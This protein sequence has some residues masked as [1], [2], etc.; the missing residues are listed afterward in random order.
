MRIF[1][2]NA[3]DYARDYE[4]NGYAHVKGGVEPE[5]LKFALQQYQRLASS[6]ADM[7]EWEFKGKKL[8]FLFE[9]PENSD[10]PKGVKDAVATVAGLPK[11]RVTLCERHLKAYNSTA[12]EEP[13]AHKDRAASQVTV[14][15]PLVVPEGSHLKLYPEHRR[16]MNLFGSTALYRTSLDEEDLPENA[17]AQVEP[18]RIEV[19]P[20]DVILFRGSCIY[21]ERQKPANTTLLYLKFNAFDLDPIGEDP[22]TPAQRTSSMELLNSSDE[23]LLN[24]RVMVSPQLDEIKRT[25]SRIGW[26][27]II[28]ARVFGGKEFGLSEADFHLLKSLPTD[29]RPTLADLLS[30]AGFDVFAHREQLP[31][32]RRLV[33]LQ[34]LDLL[35]R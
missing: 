7:K 31:A 27:E 32:L 17:L 9:F 5:F 2:F 1:S 15:L 19:P 35:A 3:A 33:R 16:E 10:W 11:D 30:S 12:V 26:R 22:N 29:G 4:T 8:Q 34:A 20:G 18:L 28:Q 23:Q 6:S 24:L 21:H 25:Y 14:G 13:P